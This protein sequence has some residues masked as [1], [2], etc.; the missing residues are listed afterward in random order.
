V[1]FLYFVSVGS[2][3]SRDTGSSGKE[4]RKSALQETLY[5]TLWVLEKI[6]PEC[7][8]GVPE[9]PKKYPGAEIYSA[10]HPRGPRDR[11][12]LRIGVSSLGRSK[13]T[14]LELLLR[15]QRIEPGLKR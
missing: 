2:V 4:A 6:K 10:C 5:L 13:L 9:F 7:L 8:V 1:P 14:A 11:Q 3:M 15:F 12:N